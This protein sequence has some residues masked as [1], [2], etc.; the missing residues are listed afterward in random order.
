MEF[1]RELMLRSSCQNLSNYKNNVFSKDDLAKV[2]M[3]MRTYVPAAIMPY[4]E[5]NYENY[6]AETRR[7]SIMFAGLGIDLSSVS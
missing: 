6:G 3:R 1:H 2:Q 7:L 4:L 5:E